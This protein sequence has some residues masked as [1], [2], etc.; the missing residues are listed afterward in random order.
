MKTGA[1]RPDGS[2]AQRTNRES[3]QVYDKKKCAGRHV[4]ERDAVTCVNCQLHTR[5][6]AFEVFV[7]SFDGHSIY[8]TILSQVL[9]VS[10][11]QEHVVRHVGPRSHQVVVTIFAR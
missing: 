1:A 6:G 4:R 7:D 5:K 9:S 3:P 10:V 8:N 2:C 11:P